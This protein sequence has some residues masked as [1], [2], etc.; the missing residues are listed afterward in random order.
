MN[1]T[2]LTTTYNR[3]DLLPNLYNSLLKQL[4]RDFQWL[5]IDDGSTDNTAEVINGFLN[6]SNSLKI[7]YYL[8][9]NGG[10][11]TA[12]N[13]SHQYI[14]GDIVVIIDS[15]DIL[16]PE[17][18]STIKHYW[19]SVYNDKKFATVVFEQSD[20]FGNKLGEFPNKIFSGSDLDYRIKKSI[21]GDFAETIRTTVLKEFYFPE[22]QSENFFPEGWLWTKVAL[23]YN[24]LNVSKILVIGGYQDDGLTKKGRLLRTNS[25]VNMMIYYRLRETISRMLFKEK[26][27]SALAFNVYELYN[28]KDIHSISKIEYVNIFGPNTIL[29]K[30]LRLPAHVI[31]HAWRMHEVKK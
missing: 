24:T 22:Q 3:G 18:I 29:E 10:K 16:V 1:V 2:I 19:K 27:M 6:N 7:E 23:K 30:V 31:Y 21:K 12:L 25:P 20:K 11:Y 14:K 26:Y 8:K 17:A 4:D 13:Y 28:Q 5:I 9:K 15:D